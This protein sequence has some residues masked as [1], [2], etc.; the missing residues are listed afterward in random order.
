VSMRW[1]RGEVLSEGCGSP[2]PDPPS[3][4]PCLP[5]GPVVGKTPPS[6]MRSTTLAKNDLRSKSG[7]T[8]H[9][10]R[11][12]SLA[13][14]RKVAH[15][16]SRFHPSPYFSISSSHSPANPAPLFPPTLRRT[17]TIQTVNSAQAGTPGKV[18][19]EPW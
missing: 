3:L 4:L 6:K 5:S 18:A 10:A 11:R 16:P 8:A 12:E 13:V 7:V 14:D 19:V 17:A 1:G 9:C 15:S 2:H